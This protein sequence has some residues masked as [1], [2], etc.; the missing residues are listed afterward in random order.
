MTIWSL[1]IIAAFCVAGASG[2]AMK[3]LAFMHSILV[4]VAGKLSSALIL[5]NL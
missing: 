5:I 1:T 4:T 2:Y 3:S